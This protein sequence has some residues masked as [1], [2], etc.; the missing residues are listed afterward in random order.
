MIV[1]DGNL[2]PVG[3]T[4]ITGMTAAK[5]LGDGTLEAIPA[6]AKYALIQ[7][8][9]QGVAWRDDGTDP[10]ASIGMQLPAGSDIWYVGNLS[11][12]KAILLSSGAILNVTFYGY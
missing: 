5:G 8:M 11:A 2:S 6:N 1:I 12:F 7:A 3:F 10:T 4:Q 9:T